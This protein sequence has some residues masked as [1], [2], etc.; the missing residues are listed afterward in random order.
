[1]QDTLFQNRLKCRWSYLRANVLSDAAITNWIDTT[2]LYLDEGQIRNFTQ[3]PILG[4]Y[5]WPN[6]NPIP[7]NYAGEITQFKNWVIARTAWLDANIPGNCLSVGTSESENNSSFGVFP[8]PNNGSFT[9]ALLRA[10]GGIEKIEVMD[11]IGRTIYLKSFNNA[12]QA[13]VSAELNNG[14]YFV[15]V[16]DKEGNYSVQK[17]IIE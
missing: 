2:A 7:A 5:V 1:M 12:S 10:G 16:T 8:N 6:P 17:I 11:M 4:V 3:W 15:K 9:V 14:I 13:A